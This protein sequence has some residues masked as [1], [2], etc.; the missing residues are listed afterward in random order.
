MREIYEIVEISLS[1]C[2]DGSSADLDMIGITVR[3]AYRSPPQSQVALSG[4][5]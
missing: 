4:A 2:A 5:R 1:D 3:A